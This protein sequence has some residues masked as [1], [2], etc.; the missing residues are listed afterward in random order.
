MLNLT[1]GSIAEINTTNIDID[2]NLSA[3]CLI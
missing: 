3:D 2:I 1:A